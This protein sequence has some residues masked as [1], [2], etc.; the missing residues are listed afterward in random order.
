[1]PTIAGS[2]E[3][4]SLDEEVDIDEEY[5]ARDEEMES[6]HAESF[7]T[8]SDE[9]PQA[10]SRERLGSESEMDI[11]DVQD[12]DQGEDGNGKQTSVGRLGSHPSVNSRASPPSV[13]ESFISRRW[14]RDQ[15]A[16]TAST[17]K[18]ALTFRAK[19]EWKLYTPAF[20]AFWLGFVCPVL[21]LVGGW[22]FTRFGEQPP[23]I[24]FWEFYFMGCWRG[25]RLRCCGRRKRGVVSE[26]G[27]GKGVVVPGVVAPGENGKGKGKGREGTELPLPKW[28]TEKQ[29]SDDG[30]ARLHDPK[31]SLRGISFGYPFIPRPVQLERTGSWGAKATTRA[32]AVLE[33]PNRLFDLLYGVKLKEVRG[34]PESGRRMFDPWIQRCRYAFCYALIFV[35]VGLCT[36]STYLI[37]YN[38]RELR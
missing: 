9:I 38:T 32:V 20:W 25:L 33:K 15:D 26:E 19:R 16:P 14:N 24:T 13:S 12:Q 2:G 10:D 28:V 30:R 21:W 36:A 11:A 6:L 8:A 27:K 18:V 3:S 7:V 4:K 34:R 1:M 37:V 35:C 29:S 17:M 31:R 5:Y 22:H 23:R